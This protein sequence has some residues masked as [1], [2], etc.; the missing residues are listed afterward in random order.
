MFSLHANIANSKRIICALF[1]LG[2]SLVFYSKKPNK[3][4]GKKP[5]IISSTVKK[6]KA[7]DGLFDKASMLSS[8]KKLE[9][10][11]PVV[12]NGITVENAIMIEL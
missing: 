7:F 6:Y 3:K 12:V 9:D 4:T 10:N 1:A 8:K 5:N 2:L 11:E